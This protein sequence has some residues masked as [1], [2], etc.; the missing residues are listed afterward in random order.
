MIFHEKGVN[1]HLKWQC[2]KEYVFLQNLK[3][4]GMGMR[5]FSYCTFLRHCLDMRDVVIID[6]QLFLY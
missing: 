1:F 4:K 5:K 3:Y 2:R 6:Y